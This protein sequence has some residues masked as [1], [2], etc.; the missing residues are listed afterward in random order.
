MSEYKFIMLIGISHRDKVI[1]GHRDRFM[2][3][4]GKGMSKGQDYPR[5]QVGG[6]SITK[7]VIS[8]LE[9]ILYLV[10]IYVHMYV[11]VCGPN[12]KRN[13]SVNT[14]INLIY[15][16]TITFLFLLF[17]VKALFNLLLWMWCV[18]VCVSTG[19]YVITYMWRSES[20]ICDN[21]YVEVRE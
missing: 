12:V 17:L 20:S 13:K 11:K 4:S 14:L 6:D 9:G 21:V 7:M 2:W 19:A 8:R 15:Y 3:H 18:W 1:G 10:V 5:L 16:M